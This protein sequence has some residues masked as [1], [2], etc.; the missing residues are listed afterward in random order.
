MTLIVKGLGSN[1]I[2]IS[3]G[4][5]DLGKGKI[6]APRGFASQKIPQKPPEI[7]KSK[8]DREMLAIA[9]SYYESATDFARDE[10]GG[11][12]NQQKEYQKLAKQW[13]KKVK[14]KNFKDFADDMFL[15]R[16]GQGGKLSYEIEDLDMIS[17]IV[18]AFLSGEPVAGEYEPQ[19]YYG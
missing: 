2:T 15:Y 11:S 1:P 12:R 6:N 5:K 13:E 18:D 17:D 7:P 14:I 4:F 3:E 10:S 9:Y 16:N 19:L 8:R